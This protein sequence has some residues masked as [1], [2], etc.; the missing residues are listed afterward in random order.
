M[1]AINGRNVGVR[2]QPQ[3]LAPGRSV[4]ID[5]RTFVARQWIEPVTLS[6]GA[7]SVRSRILPSSAPFERPC[8]RE[9]QPGARVSGLLA[10]EHAQNSAEL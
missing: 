9:H 5:V 4:I 3:D 1:S 7:V 10:A 2:P 6:T 8:T